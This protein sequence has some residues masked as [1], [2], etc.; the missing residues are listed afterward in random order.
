ML[1]SSSFLRISEGTA[2]LL[3]SHLSIGCA[4]LRCVEGLPPVAVLG[5]LLQGFLLLQIMDTRRVVP[6]TVAHRLGCLLT[7]GSFPDPR[8]N[9][10]TLQWQ[11]PTTGPPGRF[12][13]LNP[14]PQWKPCVGIG[15]IYQ[16]LFGCCLEIL[17]TNSLSLRSVSENATL[18]ASNNG[19][20]SQLIRDNPYILVPPPLQ[21]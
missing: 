21:Q 15:I 14:C 13:I 19:Y 9:L 5:L 16:P 17:R 8:S 11:I 7:C 1:K 12:W 3:F 18:G 4:G 2:W 10:Y 6:V 20:Y